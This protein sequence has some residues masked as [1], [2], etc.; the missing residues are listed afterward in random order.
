[1]IENDPSFELM[2][3]LLDGITGRTI[4]LADSARARAE[5]RVG[6]DAGDSAVLDDPT[7]I[8][9]LNLASMVNF[10]AVRARKLARGGEVAEEAAALLEAVSSRKFHR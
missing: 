7:Y 8:A 2:A 3:A 5:A 4:N 1:M 6:V 10:L 9:M